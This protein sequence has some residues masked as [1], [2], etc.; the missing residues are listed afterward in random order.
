MVFDAS[1]FSK[2][3]ILL[4]CIKLLFSISSVSCSSSLLQQWYDSPVHQS[5]H[6]SWC[7]PNCTSGWTQHINSALRVLLNVCW[8]CAKEH[9]DKATGRPWQGHIHY[10]LLW[11]AAGGGGGGIMIFGCFGTWKYW[12]VSFTLLCGKKMCHHWRW[13]MFECTCS[14]HYLLC[15]WSHTVKTFMQLL[16]MH[17]TGT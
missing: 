6:K 5:S 9:L 11:S 17:N 16:E 14:N 2:V 1:Q 8:K 4:E 7:S 15:S 13:W 10:P 3:I 12:T